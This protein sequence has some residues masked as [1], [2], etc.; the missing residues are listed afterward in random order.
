ML[1][2]EIGPSHPGALGEI[3]TWGYQS[4]VIYHNIMDDFF[5]YADARVVAGVTRSDLLVRSPSARVP[6]IVSTRRLQARLAELDGLDETQVQWLAASLR[7]ACRH[8][9]ALEAVVDQ[10]AVYTDD[11][12][13]IG[14]V[15]FQ[16][17]L[18]SLLR[19]IAG[20]EPLWSAYSNARYV[21]QD[22]LQWEK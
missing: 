10:S 18:C 8:A 12:I 20:L 9:C 2:L 5:G 13:W 4:G 15:H 3:K 1:L 6:S 16:R 22:D 14:L 7:E 21:P 19:T 17:A 11:N